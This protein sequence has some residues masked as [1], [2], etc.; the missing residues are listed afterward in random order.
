MIFGRELTHPCQVQNRRQ[1][2]ALQRVRKIGGIVS[3]LRATRWSAD[4]HRF[5]NAC[6]EHSTGVGQSGRIH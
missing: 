6:I 2:V 3:L 4:A 1:V 5:Q